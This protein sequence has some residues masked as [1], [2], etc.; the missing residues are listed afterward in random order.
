MSTDF[1][2]FVFFTCHPGTEGALKHELARTDPEWRPSYSRRGF[3]TFK[4]PDSARLDAHALASRSWVFARTQSISLGRIAA[5]NLA[6]AAAQAWALDRVQEL[7]AGK[8]L[9]AIHVWERQ[10]PTY[11][12]I[13]EL[14]N[15]S[16]LARE[17]EAA[18]RAAAP[19]SLARFAQASPAVPRPTPRNRRILDVVLVEPHEWWIGTHIAMTLPQRWPGGLIPIAIP[20]RAVSRAYVKMEDALIWSGLPV[21]A[22]D[23]CIEIGCSPGG[24]SQALLDRGL[25]VTGIDPAEVDPAVLAHPRFRHLRKRSKEVRR[26]EFMGVRWLTADVNLAPTYTL[27]TVEAVIRHPGVR[28]RGMVLTLKMANWS[29]AERL[30]EFGKRV[31]SWGYREVRMRQL[32]TGGQE[33]CL[34]ALKRKELRRIGRKRQSRRTKMDQSG[35]AISQNGTRTERPD[36]PHAMLPG[37]HF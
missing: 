11:E 14:P 10:P 3:V 6:A 28:I 29:M 36:S 20:A 9:S 32:P 22:G 24:A 5:A 12:A 16:P 30:P 19:E 8:L 21:K 23:E 27:D 34:V 26:S 37:P 35:V 25:F 1:P 31:R 4:L 33:V 17:I 2:K 7:A 15:P 18:I 13:T